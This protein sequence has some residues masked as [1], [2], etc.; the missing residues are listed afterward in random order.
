M[1]RRNRIQLFFAFIDRKQAALTGLPHLLYTLRLLLVGLVGWLGGAQF[2]DLLANLLFA[3]AILYGLQAG[4]RPNF[5]NPPRWVGPWAGY[6]LLLLLEAVLGTFLGS[7]SG[8]FGGIL[9]LVLYSAALIYLG[10]GDR[11][12]SVLAALPIA[13]MFI[14]STALESA[15]TSGAHLL[16]ALLATLFGGL[17]LAGASAL[18]EGFMWG[19]QVFWTVVIATLA[20][21]LPVAY[22]SQVL[23]AA[24][25]SSAAGQVVGALIGYLIAAAIFSWPAWLGIFWDWVKRKVTTGV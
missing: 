25:E 11:M 9:W 24:Q 5:R 14:W 18:F 1:A 12:R 7:P 13:P 17:V 2:W 23:E 20:G 4:L 19:R 10:R 3:G 21:G 6:S 8:T 15:L 16:P 22:V